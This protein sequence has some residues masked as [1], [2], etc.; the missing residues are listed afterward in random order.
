RGAMSP[1]TPEAGRYFNP[2]WSPDGKRIAY[3]RYD[4]GSPLI[5]MKSSDGSDAGRALTQPK[6][7]AEFPTAWSP[8]GSIRVHRHLRSEPVRGQASRHHRHLGAA[9]GRKVSVT[10]VDGNAPQR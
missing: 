10:P 7:Y 8:D 5:C 4:E 9:D 3:A 1:F 6:D 2:V